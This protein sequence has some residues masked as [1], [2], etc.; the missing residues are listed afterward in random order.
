MADQ[1]LVY[2]IDYVYIARIEV[3][4]IG[5][6]FFLCLVIGFYSSP[7][8]LL[9]FLEIRSETKSVYYMMLVSTIFFLLTLWIRDY[10]LEQFPNS[11][12]EYAYLFQADMFSKGKLWERAHDLPDF[13]YSNNIAQFDGIL[14][15]RF[16]PGWPLVLSGAFEI[17]MNP[18]LVNPLLGVLCLVVFFLFVKKYYNPTVAVWSLA[19]LALTGMYLYNSA[20]YFS[21]VSCLLV[22]LLFVFNIYLYREREN[23]LYALLAGLFLGFVVVIRY[24][25]AV[26]IFVPFLACLLLEYKWRVVKLF[27]WMG[28]GS[29]PC[30]TYLFWYNYSITGNALVP[31]TMWAYPSEQ[32][33]FVKGHNFVRGIEHVARRTLMF[34]YWASPGLLILYV[35]YLFRKVKSPVERFAR[36]EDYTFLTLAIGYFFYYQIGGNQYG[37]RFF[38]EALPFLMV[39]VVSKVIASRERW[40]TAL[41]IASLLY[42]LIKLPFISHREATIIDQRQDVYD[43]VAEQKIHNAVVFVA[44]P[45]SPIRPMPEADLTRNGSKFLSDVVYVLEIPHINRQVMDY[46]EDRKV[47]RYVRA[48]DD[49]QGELIRI[50]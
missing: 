28:V 47:Y 35:V 7:P 38:F 20:S 41:L 22:T 13:F 8:A 36:P 6:F 21:H 44:S 33:G 15:S 24:Y 48:V 29:V 12:D 9:K 34:M 37:P 10:V 19:G 18:A 14:V 32:L 26:L 50:R 31:V 3:L 49:P 5:F 25:T 23:I 2:Y 1:G 45:T 16:P 46:Y 39:F 11:S 27:F 42:P 40:A 30:L 17:G 43:L 4:W